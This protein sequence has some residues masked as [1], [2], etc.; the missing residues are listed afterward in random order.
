MRRQEEST[1]WGRIRLILTAFL[2]PF[3]ML[4]LVFDRRLCGVRQR[5][6]VLFVVVWAK[7]RRAFEFLRLARGG[8]PVR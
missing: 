7:Y 6:G 4:G 5:A 8:E 2:P 3:R 1:S